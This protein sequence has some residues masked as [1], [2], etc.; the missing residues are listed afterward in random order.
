MGKEAAGD[1]PGT[2]RLLPAVLSTTAGA[3]DVV[4]FLALGGLFTAHITGNLV[5]VAAHYLTGGFGQIGPLLSVP[6][7]VAVLG[8]VTLAAGAG[9]KA[10]RGTRRALLVLQAGLLAGSLVLAVTFGP[11]ADPDSPTAVVVGMLGVAAM[12]T[13]NALVK[14]AL[15]GTPSTAVM[16]TNITQL[17]VDLAALVRSRGGPDDLARIRHRARVTFPCVVGFVAGCAAGAGLEVR[18]GLW[19]LALPV[20]LAASA[21][22]LGELRR[23][24]PAP[25]RDSN[26]RD[27]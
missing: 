10:G 7:F 6:V 1:P 17:I 19:A 5:I 18:L 25:H 20:V 2:G 24:G 26:R 14:L 16:T 27:E 12:A 4:S 11:F 23:V 15:P 9:A 8:V 22:L 13:Q 21:V 3:A